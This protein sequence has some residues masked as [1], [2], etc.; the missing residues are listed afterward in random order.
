MKN[1]NENEKMKNEKWKKM[2][3]KWYSWKDRVEEKQTVIHW[4]NGF[5][6]IIVNLQ[7]TNLMNYHDIYFTKKCIV[8][9]NFFFYKSDGGK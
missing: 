1:E 2:I 3:K 4:N 6:S 9:D 8:V 5:H 7:F